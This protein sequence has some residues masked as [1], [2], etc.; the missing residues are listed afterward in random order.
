MSKINTKDIELKMEKSNK[1]KKK[2][3][4][5][6]EMAFVVK[7]WSLV[8]IKELA[9]KCQCGINLIY[10]VYNGQRTDNRNILFEA[11]KQ[12]SAYMQ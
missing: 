3:L 12:I 6:S 11:Y 9:E 5:E 1:I 7:Y 8:N 10:R 2:V 4:T